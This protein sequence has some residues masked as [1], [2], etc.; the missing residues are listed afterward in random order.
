MFKIHRLRDQNLLRHI[1]IQEVISGKATLISDSIELLHLVKICLFSFKKKYVVHALELY[2][3]SYGACLS[4]Y[5]YR[6]SSTPT[7]KP[8][9]IKS[10]CGYALAILRI[11]LLRR[12]AKK[13]GLMLISS[14]L[15]KQYLIDEGSEF[16]IFVV[17]NKPVIAYDQK[18]ITDTCRQ[19]VIILIGNMYSMKKHFTTIVNFALLKNIPVRCYGL[20]PEDEVWLRGKQF[21][22]V[23]VLKRVEQN[24]I[25]EILRYSKY[26][27]CLY[28]NGSVNNIY[29]SSSKVFELLFYG[30]IPII[31]DN[32]GLE[33]ELNALG[34]NFVRIEELGKKL[35]QTRNNDFLMYSETCQFSSELRKLNI[36]I[37]RLNKL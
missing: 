4:E 15:R 26:A 21:K 35:L 9:L 25:S 34:A 13:S 27:L 31:S 3:V 16:E 19:S 11:F 14:D 5:R 33:V 6:W 20:S 8:L 23:E 1:A 2:S 10:Y 29:S 7:L 24:S 36:L 12:L 32:Q 22:N 18:H 17:K 37:D 28:S 30:V